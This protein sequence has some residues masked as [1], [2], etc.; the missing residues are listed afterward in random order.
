MKR[1]GRKRPYTVAGVRRLS[2]IRCGQ[3]AEHQWNACADGLWRPLCI[4]CD[5]ALNRL[6]LHFMCIPDAKAKLCRYKTQLYERR[7]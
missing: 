5:L 7:L 6:T 2:C 1:Y 4:H 3:P